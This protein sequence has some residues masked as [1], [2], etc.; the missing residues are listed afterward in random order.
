MMDPS[1]H[2]G[3]P[4]HLQPR[5]HRGNGTSSNN[6]DNSNPR[7]RFAEEDAEPS[8]KVYQPTPRHQ[9]LPAAASSA[10]PAVYWDDR[11]NDANLAQYT[12]YREGTPTPPELEGERNDFGHGRPLDAS[13]ASSSAAGGGAAAGSEHEY[14]NGPVSLGGTSVSDSNGNPRMSPTKKKKIIRA[15]IVIGVLIIIGIAV[16]VGVGLGV[17]LANRPAEQQAGGASRSIYS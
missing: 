14:N 5:D 9:K 7:V 17:G 2:R 1:Q 15:I 16:G 8:R 6:H 3:P 12:F 13:V 11:D 10:T 4:S